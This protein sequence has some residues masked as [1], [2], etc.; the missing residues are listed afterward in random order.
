M[1]EL[2]GN[3]SV[4]AEGP[5]GTKALRFEATAAKE[6]FFG[7][8][9]L[10]TLG[11]NPHEYD[12]LKVEVKADNC[13]FLQLTLENYPE[14]GDV[15]NWYPLDAINRGSD[16]R[17]VWLDLKRPEEI[18]PKRASS[19]T[20]ALVLAGAVRDV[21]W[22]MQG[23]SRCLWLKNLRL[24]RKAIDLECD[25]TKAPHEW[26][27]KQDLVYRYAVTVANRLDQPVVARLSLLPAQVTYAYARLSEPRVELKPKQSKTIEVEVRLAGNIAARM[28]TLYCE[29]YE[30]RGFAE[31]I[32]DSETTII[33]SKVF[34]LALS[35]TVPLP[36][37]K[38][39][40]PLM[41]RPKD[42][43]VAL[44]GFDENARKKAEAAAE[45]VGPDDL[46]KVLD[47][48]M[49]R[50]FAIDQ[51]KRTFWYH[52]GNPPVK[53]PTW[54]YLNGLTACAFLY[55]T[56]GEKKYLDKGTAL[57]LR[58]AELW[59]RDFEVWRKFPVIVGSHG[60]LGGNTLALGWAT[61]GYTSPFSMQRHGMF[62]DF[63][64]LAKDMD[65]AARE[66]IIRDF[67][68]PAAVRMQQHILYYNAQA[69]ADYPILYAAFAS[70]N[71]PLA[72]CAFS[73]ERGIANLMQWS[74]DEEGCSIEGHYHAST[75]EPLLWCSELLYGRGIDLYDLRMGT[76]LHSRSA[77]AAG[78]PFKGPIVDF[79]D[80]KRFPKEVLAEVTRPS[81]GL[82]LYS[83]LTLLSWKGLEF[84]M[85]WG[86]HIYRSCPDRCAL[87]L[88]VKDQAHPLAKAMGQ[89][90]GGTY[91]HSS[92]QQSVII[93]D[94]STQNPVSARATGF[95]VDGPVQFVQATSD[96]HY[97]GTTITR[98][99]AIVGPHALAVDRVVGQGPHTVD[100]ML[101][102]AGPK[103]SLANMAEKTGGFTTKPDEAGH[104]FGAKLH[105][106]TYFIGT[107]DDTWTEGGGRLTMLGAKGTE[108]LTFRLPETWASSIETQ[109]AG[110][111]ALMVRRRNV[112]QTDFVACFS[113]ASP[114]IERLPVETAAGQEARAV[115]L[116]I[117]L[118]GGQPFQV[119]VNFE[120]EGMEVVLGALRTKERFASDYK[121]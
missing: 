19:E 27:P 10:K 93:V 89:L 8:L 38:L 53:E 14:P 47:A 85:N 106:P 107:T 30:L 16:W 28:P 15:S 114:T 87:G 70:R 98:T 96:A 111:A 4:V 115:G 82:H 41:P 71:W 40:F 34:P 72:S 17:T 24:T 25:Q 84:R 75:I 2:R 101:M 78:Y 32:A 65:P 12:L 102:L 83:G 80:A 11:V 108:V 118:K 46:N 92:L 67:I 69:V 35:V 6:D 77:R 45:A 73:S 59:Q 55:D 79:V 39:Q 61:G 110:K 121:E 33:R 81:D 9:D 31:G 60:I 26:G 105:S 116:K 18:Q 23:D 91:L 66:K 76:I 63:D 99:F 49:E 50:S 68:V 62:N 104:I 54:R 21:R 1:Q 52:A 120:P 100:W 22:R 64:L 42:L 103:V 51:G 74:F 48:P 112:T 117:T 56:T 37:A 36:E 109:K 86:K 119:L 20:P 57:L 58:A 5:G 3:L 94:E 43:P 44:T 90:G 13:A 88:S 113:A 95:D 7:R 97:P 29:R